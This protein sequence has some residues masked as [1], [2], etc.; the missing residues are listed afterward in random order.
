MNTKG[1]IY[2][3]SGPSGCGKNTVF[4]EL[5]KRDDNIVQTVSATTRPARDGETDGVEYYFVSVEDFLAKVSNEEFVEYVSYGGNYYGTLKSEVD[6]LVAMNK[7]VILIIEVNGA[8]NIKKIYP[9][10]VSIFLLPPSVEEL[11]HR[12]DKRGQ[13]SEAETERRLQIA[14]D[15]MKLK[16]RYDY[17]VI[18]AE[19]GKCVDD[20]Y[21]I[22]NK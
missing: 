15:E 5:I 8:F 7:K 4:E 1:G 17:N 10:C 12:I 6:R 2:V 21:A 22:I 14:L 16:D 20:V 9:E 19:L 13:N 3:L 18:N 11:R